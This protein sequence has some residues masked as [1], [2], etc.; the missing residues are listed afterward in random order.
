MSV[1][2]IDRIISAK[3]YGG[4]MTG[5]IKRCQRDFLKNKGIAVQIIDLDKPQGSPVKARIWQ[6]QWVADC[7]CNTTMFVDPDE[8]IFFCFGCGNRL[9]GKRPRPVTFP[10][11][12]ERKEIERLLLERPVEDFAGLTDL[13]RVGLQKALLEVQVEEVDEQALVL[14]VMR[15]AEMKK[16][17][18][19]E[20]PKRVVV[21]PLTRSWYPGE[22]PADL[23]R[24]Q[25]SAIEKWQKE[26]RRG[27]Q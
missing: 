21:K 5:Y 20:I 10:P 3:D 18:N 7:E 25:R 4:S 8:P 15:D 9:N 14:S 23:E 2:S 1:T 26:L 6:S 17:S 12:A 27:I 19:L 16:S 13:E 11:T 24:Q 22:T